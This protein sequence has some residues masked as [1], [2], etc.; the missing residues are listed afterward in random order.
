MKTCNPLNIRYNPQNN[1]IGQIGEHKGFCVFDS[2]HYGIRAAHKLLG[3]YWNKY[4]CR[5]IREFICRWAP[6]TENPTDSYIK[7]VTDRFQKSLDSPTFSSDFIL[8][9]TFKSSAPNIARLI[10]YMA[11]FETPDNGITYETI[12][13]II[14]SL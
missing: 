1:W 2:N 5:T 12:F 8:G 9:R 3:T 4:G 11:D 7:Y 10:K 14:K 6:P 13:N